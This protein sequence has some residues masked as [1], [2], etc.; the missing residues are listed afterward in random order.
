MADWVTIS[1]LATAGGTLV[2]AGATFASV[3]S[4]NRAARVAE[5]SLLAA[6]RPLLMPSRPEDAP[7]K[8]SFVDNHYAMA[9]GGGGTAEVT[10]GV[11]YLTMSVRNAGSGIAVLDRWRVELSQDVTRAESPPLD[12]FRRLTRD[13]YVPAGDVAF[14]QGAY[15]DPT[16]PEFVAVSALITARERIILDLLY[17]DHHGGQRVITRFSL[18]PRE[19]GSWLAMVARHWNVDRPDPR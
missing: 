4:A 1:A 2:L 9:P 5:E 11:I 19:D 15:R 8:V 14:W 7:V 18:V 16:E 17:G 13:I 10:G 3:R 6:I 12:T